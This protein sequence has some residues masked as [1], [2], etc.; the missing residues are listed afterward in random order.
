MPR[1]QPPS[2]MSEQKLR[3]QTARTNRY[4]DEA[5]AGDATN[6]NR[7]VARENKLVG[8]QAMERALVIK[9]RAGALA[10]GR[11]AVGG[12]AAGL[13][14]QPDGHQGGRRPTGAPPAS[15]LASW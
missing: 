3:T 12:Q 9:G 8:T 11:A 14:A 6:Y 15:W 4:V 2:K 10:R 1:G 13:Q 7:E 5:N